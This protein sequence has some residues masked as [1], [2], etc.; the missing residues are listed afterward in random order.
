[1]GGPGSGRTTLYRDEFAEEARALC[2]LGATDE[3]LADHFGV[4]RR[5]IARWRI[6]NR[7]FAE[8]LTAGKALS[9]ERVVRSLYSRAIGY[10]ERQERVVFAP[11]ASTP[12]IVEVMTHIPAD[13]QAAALWLRNRRPAE[14]RDRRTIEHSG[15]I[16][17]ARIVNAFVKPESHG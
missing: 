11:G 6:Q 2:E 1:M 15:A 10:E 14:W 17:H 13:P 16:R 12:R 7:A 5:T 4:W 3:E 9:D 8:A